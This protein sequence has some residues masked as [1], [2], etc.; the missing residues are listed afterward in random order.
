[1]SSSA[2]LRVVEPEP[3]DLT[4][5]ELAENP[6]VPPMPP[7]AAGAWRHQRRT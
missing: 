3:A 6:S 5:D 2:A 7:P 1:M 4:L